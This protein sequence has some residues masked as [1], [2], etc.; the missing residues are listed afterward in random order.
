MAHTNGIESFWSMLK[1]AH[2]GTFPRLDDPSDPLTLYDDNGNGRIA[3][4][5][6]REHGIA[7]VYLSHPAY[8]CM[9]DPDGDGVGHLLATVHT[10]STV[11][12]PVFFWPDGLE[13]THRRTV[14]P[15]HLQLGRAYSAVMV[16]GQPIGSL[17]G[18]SNGDWIPR[19]A[20]TQERWDCYRIDLQ[21]HKGSRFPV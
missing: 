10:N 1:R 13:D 8:A 12:E 9:T 19:A 14:E 4:A 20:A 5:E 11:L 6:A 7:P 3:C 15:Q 16:C 18:S 2:K 21:H 17:S